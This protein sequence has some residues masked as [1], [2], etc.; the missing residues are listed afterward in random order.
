MLQSDHFSFSI[1]ALFF[2]KIDIS[3]EGNWTSRPITNSGGLPITFDA[4]PI[5]DHQTCIIKLLA[6]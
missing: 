3:T 5:F 4:L 6:K 1:F 2:V